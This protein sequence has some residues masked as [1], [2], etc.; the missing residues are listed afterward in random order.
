MTVFSAIQDPIWR[1]VAAILAATAGC[2]GILLLLQQFVP[3]ADE[4]SRKLVHLSVVAVLPVW[5]Y[6]FDRWQ[7]AALSMAI[8]L[9]VVYPAL[10]LLEKLDLMRYLKAVTSERKPGEL[11]KSLLAL[12]FMFLMLIGVCW[13]WMGKRSLA[14]AAILAWGPGD[15]AA[16]LIGKRWGKT[17]IGR[18]KK[19]SLEGTGAMFLLSWLC[20]FVVLLLDGSFTAWQALAV[21]LLTGAVSAFTELAVLSGYDTLFC[22]AAAMT[23]LCLAWLLCR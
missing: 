15:A 7:T 19:K 13:A 3:F 5:L 16:A 8:F 14:L 23:V 18:A 20:V 9:A 6:A 2:A 11:R 1:G 10:I 12:G 21:S 17:K 22:P 4:L